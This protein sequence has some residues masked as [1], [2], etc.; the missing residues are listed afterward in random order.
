MWNV[1]LIYLTFSMLSFSDW[2]RM[3]TNLGRREKKQRV[4]I[5]A[6]EKNLI[7]SI[8]PPLKKIQILIHTINP[9][10]NLLKF[11]YFKLR[12]FLLNSRSISE[13]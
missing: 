4:I 13:N 3:V 1:N 7:K 10:M 8:N 5:H 12:L 2:S 11:I 9:T 6:L